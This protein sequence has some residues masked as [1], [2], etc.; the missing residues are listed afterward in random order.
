MKLTEEE[1]LDKCKELLT[2]MHKDLTKDEIRCNSGD[3]SCI[4]NPTSEFYDLFGGYS[5]RAIAEFVA[6][7]MNKKIVWEN[8][9][10]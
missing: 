7:K 3:Y 9:D 6:K 8:E 5:I 10:Y 2:Y 1:Y 4:M